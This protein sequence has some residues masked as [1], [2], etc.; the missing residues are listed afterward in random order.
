MVTGDELDPSFTDA[1]GDALV[2]LDDNKRVL[3]EIGAWP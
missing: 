2:G 1:F 3:Q